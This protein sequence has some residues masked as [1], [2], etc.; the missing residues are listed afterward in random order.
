M[1]LELDEAELL[2]IRALELA[3]ES[4][5]A[6]G[7]VSATLTYGWLLAAKGELD[8]AESVFE[9]VRSTAAELGVEPAIT[10]ALL[11]LGSIARLKG[12]H[13]RAEKL[14][15]EALRMTAA[16]GDR[17][18][19]PDYQAVLAATL[20]DLGKVDEAEQLALEARRNASPEDTAC[21]I[22]AETALAAVRAVQGRDVEAEDGFHS[23]LELTREGGFEVY[24]VEPLERLTIFLRDRGRADEAAPYEAR[25]VELSPPTRT[26]P[27][28]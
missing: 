4:G 26:A 27:I 14:L 28:A 12:D 20:A 13:K 21:K 18:L 23:A 10:S 1:R 19:L 9:E 5:S 25:L 3:G 7:R 22:I 6:R 11:H 17:G 15:R 2:L 24:E 8:E 16:R